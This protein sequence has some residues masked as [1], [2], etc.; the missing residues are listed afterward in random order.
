MPLFKPRTRPEI[1]R[2]MIARVIARSTLVGLLR[3]SVVF[4]TLA[5]AADEDAEQYFQLVNL[6]AVFSI[7]KATGSDLDER[8][9]EIQPATIKRRRSLFSSGNMSL[10]REG[11]VGNLNIPAG[12][13][14][15]AEDAEGQ[16]KYRTTVAAT[17]LDGFSQVIGIGVV[18]LEAGARGNAAAGTIVQIVSRTPGLTAVSNP[19]SFDNGQDREGDDRFRARLKLYVQGL[20]RGTP[21]AIRSFALNVQLTDGRRVLFA[22]VSEPV[23]PTGTYD[24]F[25]DDGTGFI[26]ETDNGFQFSLDTLISPAL[27]GETNLFTS[28]RPLVPG[29]LVAFKNAVAMVENV[30]FVVNTANG[31]LELLIP[32]VAGDIVTANYV[33]FIGLIQET[34]RVID[35]DPGALLT[36]PGVRAAG[37]RAI[38]KAATPIPQTL[39]ASASVA[40]DFDAATVIEQVI[41]EIQSYINN[42]DIG[43]S[44]IVAEIIERAMAVPGMFN[45]QITDLSGTFPAVD[46]FILPN[47]VAR[48]VSANISVV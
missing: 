24:V 23:V 33:F 41:A 5:A 39:A 2:E 1:L 21:V 15:A 42:L 38:V 29:S 7:D 22:S 36:F 47:Q 32:L 30:D 17:I 48:I 34:Q 11:T 20:S 26:T 19:A 12:T 13:I 14:V 8:A 25:I 4:H 43:R 44:V 3:N 16:I 31:Q 37:T 46:Q 27:G 9:A 28:A 40:N 35:G 18:A 6:R 45:F 10:F